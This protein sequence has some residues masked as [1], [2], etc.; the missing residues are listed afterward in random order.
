MSVTD[1]DFKPVP[2]SFFWSCDV[3][4]G[5]VVYNII[6]RRVLFN[7]I[8]PSFDVITDYISIELVIIWLFRYKQ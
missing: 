3:R 6:A 1:L 4:T 7:R 5:N 8:L 2:T